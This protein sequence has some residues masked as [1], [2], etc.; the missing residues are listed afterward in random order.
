MFEDPIRSELHCPAASTD[1][2]EF[3]RF[4]VAPSCSSSSC[5]SCR[6]Y[7]WR[8]QRG[9]FAFERFGILKKIIKP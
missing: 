3:I 9:V 5:R 7:F 1:S 8:D 4:I 6:W 2:S